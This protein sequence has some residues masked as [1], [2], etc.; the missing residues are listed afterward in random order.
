MPALTK[1]YEEG[2]LPNGIK[3]TGV[4]RREWEDGSSFQAFVLDSLESHARDIPAG[5]RQR[6]V[7]EVVEYRTADVTDAGSVLSALQ[8]LD[9]P[10]LAYLALPPAVFAPTI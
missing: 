4:D 2:K 3:V 5:V 10:I 6:M 1:L 7:D 9:R 8:P